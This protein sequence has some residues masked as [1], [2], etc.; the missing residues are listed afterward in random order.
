MSK[1]ERTFVMTDILALGELLIDFT[2]YGRSDSGMRLFRTKPGRSGGERGLRRREVGLSTAFIGKVE[3]TC[4]AS[5]CNRCLR[6]KASI[7]AT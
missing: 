4:T 3:K 1:E 6:R 2:E 7:S 5:S